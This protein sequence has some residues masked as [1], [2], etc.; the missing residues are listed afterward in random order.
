MA[1]AAIIASYAL[2]AVLRPRRRSDAATPPNARGA[3]IEGQWLIVRLRSLKPC[4][5]GRPF[6]VRRDQW[7]DAELSQ[8]DRL[9]RR[10]VQ[11]APRT[12]RAVRGRSVCSYRVVLGQDASRMVQSRSRCRAGGTR[13]P[14]AAVV[15]SA[16]GSHRSKA[17]GRKRDQ[18][19]D[20]Q[21]VPCHGEHLA[22]HH[23]FDDLPA[24]VAELA[25]CHISH[26]MSVSR[27]R[28]GRAS[29]SIVRR[30]WNVCAARGRIRV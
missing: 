29:I 24:F 1:M 2:A 5:A 6:N 28:H 9:N 20:G 22:G 7:P 21:A 11:A 23:P 27:V 4:L 13:D 8:R 30:P 26:A 12:P 16:P 14:S 15:A 18:A 25:D 10:A 17:P 19:R 3:C